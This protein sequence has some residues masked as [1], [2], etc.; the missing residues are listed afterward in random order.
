MTNKKEKK[1][2]RKKKRVDAYV[3]DP[4]SLID[5]INV[6]GSLLPLLPIMSRIKTDLK[7]NCMKAISII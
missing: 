3:I 2:S 7:I 1:T 6:S 4:T 5:E